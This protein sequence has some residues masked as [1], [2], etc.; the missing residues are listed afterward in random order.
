MAHVMVSKTSMEVKA[1]DAGT[2]EEALRLYLGDTDVKY[3]VQ[4]NGESADYSDSLKQGDYISVG[5]KVKG[6]C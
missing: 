3:T 5:E 4:I 6:G 2:V 1:V